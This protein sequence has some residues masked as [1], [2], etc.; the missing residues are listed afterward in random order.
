MLNMSRIVGT[1]IFHPEETV[2]LELKTHKATNKS[3]SD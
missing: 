1:L 2:F 3:N